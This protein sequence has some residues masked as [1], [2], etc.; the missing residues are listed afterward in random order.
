MKLEGK[1]AIVT[2][3]SSGMGKA[4]ALQFA[5]EGASVVAVA[6]RKEKLAELV[7]YAGEEGFKILAFQGDIAK[8][9]DI[10]CMVDFAF[11]N[12]GK[13]DIL[14]NNAGIADN[15]M[16][17][18]EVSDALWDKVIGVNLTGP[19]YSCR[20]AVNIMLEQ[21]SGN[22]INIASVGGLNGSRAGVAYTASKFGLV[23]LTKNIGYMYATKGIRCNAICPGGVET[24]I[25]T[26]GVGFENPSPFGNE[27][28]MLGTATSPR[29][30]SPEEIAKVALF[31]ASDDSSFINGATIVA[32]GGWTA[33]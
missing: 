23:G 22:I 11:K 18:G 12:F 6:R 19:L 1:A 29:A 16:P 5:R 24:E 32:D 33:Y 13:V 15:N 9:E 14:V 7:Q 21:G 3:A 2:G 8:K 17:A 10:D 20:R 31:L 30:A 26:K 28:M 27:R 4:M 25:V